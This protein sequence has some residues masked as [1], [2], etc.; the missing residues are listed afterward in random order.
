MTAHGASRRLVIVQMMI[1][2][3][4]VRL[5]GALFFI[6]L[7][8]ALELEELG[9]VSIYVLI[10]NAAE[11]LV[12]NG[13]SDAIANNRIK[14]KRFGLLIAGGFAC[15][16]AGSVGLSWW[17]LDTVQSSLPEQALIA[18]ILFSLLTA[19]SFVMQGILRREAAF[20]ELAQRS[21]YAVITAF[22][23]GII[24]FMYDPSANAMLCYFLVSALTSVLFLMLKQKKYT[25]AE[26]EPNWLESSKQ[27]LRFFSFKLSSFLSGRSLELFVFLKFGPVILAALVIGS[28]IYNVLAYFLKSVLQDYIFDIH[29]EKHQ[30]SHGERKAQTQQALLTVAMLASPIFLGCAAVAEPILTLLVGAEKAAISFS[31]LK[32]FCVLGLVEVLQFIV[33]AALLSG[34]SSLLPVYLQVLR[35][36]II[37]GIYLF[38][39]IADVHT[40]VTACVL[41]SMAIPALFIIL[42]LIRGALLTLKQSI[43]L[44]MYILIATAMYFVV[45]LVDSNLQQI[46]VLARLIIAL[47][48]GVLVYAL[49]NLLL[50][51]TDFT[52]RLRMLVTRN[53]AAL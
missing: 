39:G 2:N 49:I 3:W 35:F 27:V 18:L 38:V 31:Y 24:Y 23:V 8:R 45:V 14:T 29:N 32:L 42:T 19:Y 16:I 50:N 11:L 41:A 52:T 44:G 22:I 10:F 1:K 9:I 30:T 26:T 12:D 25:H 4:F 40:F 48:V 43:T 21:T 36:G 53:K 20:S 13:V 47:P 33:Y 7:A 15:L 34:T 6:V 5:G 37:T 51:R 17:M 46:N 28:R